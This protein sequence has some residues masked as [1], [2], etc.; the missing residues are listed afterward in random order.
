[1]TMALLTFLCVLC[2]DFNIV[3][4]LR[5][6]KSWR[7][8]LHLKSA[9]NMKVKLRSVIR[10]VSTVNDCLPTFRAPSPYPNNLSGTRWERGFFFGGGGGG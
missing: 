3:C 8:C 9:Q 2:P 1:M 5:C 4:R 7:V 6:G 10:G